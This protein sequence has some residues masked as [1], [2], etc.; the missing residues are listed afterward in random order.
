MNFVL[1]ISVTP[2][3]VLAYS[4]FLKSRC[5][6]S[7]SMNSLQK[8]FVAIRYKRIT[9]ISVFVIIIVV[10]RLKPVNII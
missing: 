10:Y 9:N 1:C 7:L 4:N 2:S 3:G 5:I 6:P 8:L